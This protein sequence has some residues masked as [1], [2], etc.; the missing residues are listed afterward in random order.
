MTTIDST[1]TEGMQAARTTSYPWAQYGL[2]LVRF[3]IG[4]T[5]LAHGI[6]NLVGMFGWDVFRFAGYLGSKGYGQTTLLSWT[7]MTIELTSGVLLLLGLVTPIA[8]ALTAGVMLN[9]AFIKLSHGF[10]MPT[11]F[12]WE[13]AVLAGGLVVLLAGPGRYALDHKVLGAAA[14]VRLTRIGLGLAA[15]MLLIS[16]LIFR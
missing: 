13:L 10:F 5:F 6:Q 4:F 8:A 15:A 1:A 3:V 9:A 12:E 14:T 16:V 7:T 11:G 2:L